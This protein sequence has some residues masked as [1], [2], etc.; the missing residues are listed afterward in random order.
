[1]T[2]FSL[3]GSFVIWN[4]GQRWREG[5][6]EREDK[7]SHP[8]AWFW[9]WHGQGNDGIVVLNLFGLCKLLEKPFFFVVKNQYDCKL[10]R[11]FYGQVMAN[12]GKQKTKTYQSCQSLVLFSS[13]FLPFN[14]KR[15][16]DVKEYI[17]N[18]LSYYHSNTSVPEQDFMSALEFEYEKH[19]RVRSFL[20]VWS[21]IL[22]YCSKAYW[23]N[24]SALLIFAEPT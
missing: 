1:V 7:K 8:F 10:G 24:F 11:L 12:G 16:M 4:L 2:E 6:R 18:I 21:I 17:L 5:E 22:S 20:S 23:S 9:L 19:S 3:V 15:N 14:T 13:Y